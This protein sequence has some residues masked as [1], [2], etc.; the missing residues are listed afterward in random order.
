MEQTIFHVSL[1]LHRN[2]N[3]T[4]KILGVLV[5]FRLTILIQ[6]AILIRLPATQVRNK[7]EFKLLNLKKLRRATS[8]I[9]NRK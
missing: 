5:Y 2:K 3:V 4:T 7:K 1:F 8:Y 6:D 9:I